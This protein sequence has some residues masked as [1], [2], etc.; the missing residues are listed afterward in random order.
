MHKAI[1]DKEIPMTDIGE[2]SGI[3]CIQEDCSVVP[4]VWRVRGEKGDVLLEFLP[5]DVQNT[6]LTCCQL[7]N[8]S[9]QWV[10]IFDVRVWATLSKLQTAFELCKGMQPSVGMK[11]EVVGEEDAWQWVRTQ[12]KLSEQGLKLTWG[13]LHGK[14]KFVN[15]G[16]RPGPIAEPHGFRQGFVSAAMLAAANTMPAHEVREIF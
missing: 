11:I 2:V 13:A 1:Y 3:E 15:C 16:E 7:T 9:H 8:S 10:H 14:C 12:A 6:I 4:S 5:D